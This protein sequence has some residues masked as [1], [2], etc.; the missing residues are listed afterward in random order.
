MMSINVSILQCD[1][2]I[3]LD[4][5]IYIEYF[6]TLWNDKLNDKIDCNKLNMNEVT[7]FQK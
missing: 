2:E 1:D 5:K 4:I 6:K 7:K 3:F